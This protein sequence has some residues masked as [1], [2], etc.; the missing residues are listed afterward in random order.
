MD[1]SEVIA[2]TPTDSP[3]DVPTDVDA[4]S[5]AP[6]PHESPVDVHPSLAAAVAAHRSVF[7]PIPRRRFFGIPLVGGIS[8][9]TSICAHA[10]VI[11]IGFAV[12]RHFRPPPV[13]AFAL[14]DA[15][16][17][18]NEIFWKEQTAGGTGMRNCRRSIRRRFRP[19]HPPP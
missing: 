6:V 19:T 12:Y 3:S 5:P 7:R 16:Q 17:M 10:A 15:S 2:S 18:R 13:L 14:G 1:E 9:A 8:L 4:G 11:G